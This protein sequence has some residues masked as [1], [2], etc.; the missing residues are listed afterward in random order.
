MKNTYIHR[1]PLNGNS[2][3]KS[4]TPNM[5]VGEKEI[6]DNYYL[7]HTP[8]L[9]E[10]LEL[11]NS[12][13][14]FFQGWFIIMYLF[15]FLIGTSLRASCHDTMYHGED[16]NINGKIQV[17]SSFPLTCMYSSILG[18][19]EIAYFPARLNCH[20]F[21]FLFIYHVYH[22][23]L[24]HTITRSPKRM[25]L[26]FYRC[27]REILSPNSRPSLYKIN[28]FMYIQWNLSQRTLR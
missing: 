1:Y 4:A 5:N 3:F 28:S 26:I 11:C 15:S 2:L 25:L 27:H 23:I 18:V 21:L 17:F 6:L 19:T 22:D 20:M 10:V 24:S 16:S 8:P 9:H 12:R 14:F 7:H 13:L